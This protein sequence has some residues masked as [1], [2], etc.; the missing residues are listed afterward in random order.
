[1]RTMIARD[2]RIA[3]AW[4]IVLAVFAALGVA[5]VLVNGGW[6]EGMP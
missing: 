4:L 5:A 2:I 1:M 3:L 6:T